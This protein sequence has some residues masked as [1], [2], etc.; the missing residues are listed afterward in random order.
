MTCYFYRWT[1]NTS[2]DLSAEFKQ[3]ETPG[4]PQPPVVWSHPIPEIRE[5]THVT[6]ITHITVI[7]E[8]PGGPYKKRLILKS[9]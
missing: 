7:H 4:Q 9:L 3:V 6:L 5:N 2:C 1:C 8:V